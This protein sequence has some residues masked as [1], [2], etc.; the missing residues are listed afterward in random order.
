M[1]QIHVLIRR[2]SPALNID[3]VQVGV[4]KEGQFEPLPR[5]AVEDIP[6]SRF[7][8]SSFISDSLYVNHSEI[9]GLVTTSFPSRVFRKYSCPH[10]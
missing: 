8:K 1:A 3:L 6:V 7:L 5:S 2:V 4:I 10:V 9:F